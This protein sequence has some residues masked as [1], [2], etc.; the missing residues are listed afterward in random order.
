MAT[1]KWIYISIISV[2]I[3][4]LANTIFLY[5]IDTYNILTPKSKMYRNVPNQR[6]MITKHILNVKN[7]YNALIFG[8]SRVGYINPFHIKSYRVYNMT[9]AEGL[10]HEHLLLIKLLLHKGMRLKHLLIGLDDISYQISFKE[11]QQ[12]LGSKSYYLATGESKFIFYK[13]FFLHKVTKKDIN[14]FKYK[15]I[16][17]TFLPKEFCN[18]LYYEI[19]D[20]KKVYMQ[21]HKN[22][23]TKKHI[24]DPKFQ[25][26][27][28]YDANYIK[29]T[30][31]DIQEIVDI[32][33]KYNIDTK[34]IIV[35]MHKK[36]Y[37]YTN[38]KRFYKF[39]KEL[40]KITSYY[41]FAQ[42]NEI[43]SNNI[44]W[45][46][47]S[48]FTHEVGDMI[49]NRIYDNNISIKNFGIYVQKTN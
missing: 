34:F 11:H 14:Q 23:R 2:I 27:T 45:N 38:K 17:N 39:R 20:Q 12:Q 8:S 47:T 30:L 1:K 42:P 15:Y 26:P 28:R 37:E 6:V 43:N 40:A 4:L 49:I 46:E 13:D 31:K 32:S 18:T 48:H 25:D 10:P 35:P 44:Y 3:L 22:T 33:K 24:N 36:T 9:Y 29:E 16:T 5:N 41:D 7:N 21:K 19:Y